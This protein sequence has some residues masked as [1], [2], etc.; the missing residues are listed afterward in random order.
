MLK[1]LVIILLLLLSIS[2]VSAEYI[3]P[4]QESNLS[5]DGFKEQCIDVTYKDL[6]TNDSLINQSVKLT[7][8]VYLAQSESMYFY[9]DGNSDE[10]VFVHLF[11][12][13]D[14]SKFKKYEG[15][16]A[17]IYCRYDGMPNSMFSGDEPELTIVDIE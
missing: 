10:K 2:V 14:N 5:V 15:L 7:G 12:G 13:K 9:I 3:D 16:D 17:T 1:K 11:N 4:L 6:K 8:E